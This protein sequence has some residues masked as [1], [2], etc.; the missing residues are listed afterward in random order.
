MSYLVLARKYRPNNFDEVIGQEH[1]T[2]LLKKAITSGRVTHAYLFCGPRGIGKTS[3]ARILA[4]SLNC[5][6]GITTTPCGTCSACKE[7]AQGTSFDVLE[8][9]GASN[10]GIDEIRTLRENVKFA[11]SYGKYKIYIVDEVHML[12]TEAF[13]A[14]LKTL[15]EPPEHV[16]FI[17]ATTDPNKVPLTVV[18]RCQRYDFKRISSKTLIASLAD[19]CK[20]EKLNVEQDALFAI[21]KAA[22]GSFRDALSIL[23]QVGAITERSIKGEDV[24]SM[25]GLVEVD[26][27]FELTDALGQKDC[28]GA[29]KLFDGI[30]ERGKDI[31]QLSKDLLEHFRNLM[32]IKVGGKSLG[33][34]VDYPVPVKEQYL[35]QTE[36]FSLS[37]I[38]K[39]I[40]MLITAQDTARI[41][42]S[43]RT[44]LEI[45]FA[46]MTYRQDIPVG[47]P[48][49]SAAVA[50]KIAAV[51]ETKSPV[52]ARKFSPVDILKNQKGQ[53]ILAPEAAAF[54]EREA[55]TAIEPLAPSMEPP[56]VLVLEDI[57]RSWDALTYAVSR[58]KMSVATYLQEGI[59]IALNG[60]KLT[61]GFSK[62]FEFYKDSL[63]EKEYAQIVEKSFSESLKT[64]II[65]EY[66]T[67]DTRDVPHQAEQEPLVKSALE[68]FQGKIVSKWHND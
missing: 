52:E 44:P 47:R 68:T 34:L 3:C 18:S 59:P 41:T 17:F 6:E 65:I 12:T 49:P 2:E 27:L 63:M 48:A 9:D 37:E 36:K 45:A 67:I 54:D 4:K 7:I 32:I 39:A 53:V 26:L 23:D 19:I 51:Q 55:E 14:L 60:R 58:K 22:Q 35:A 15:E 29:F 50:P 21:A 66:K 10:R 46:K 30:I 20:K 64:G 43:L 1:I 11:P 8:I 5:Q 25:L 40:D 13:N 31:R 38:L 56:V 62:D 33:R 24:Y 57:K 61:I 16:K 42:E 28:A